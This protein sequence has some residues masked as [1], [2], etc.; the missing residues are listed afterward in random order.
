LQ[1]SLQLIVESE[2]VNFLV[3][4]L[5]WMRGNNLWKTPDLMSQQLKWSVKLG[6]KVDALSC[7]RLSIRAVSF[8]LSDEGTPIESRIAKEQI[9]GCLVVNHCYPG[10]YSRCG[11]DFG[12]FTSRGGA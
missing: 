12:V 11:L 4:R 9:G 1:V 5:E 7:G 2:V 6:S 10:R 3:R 8:A